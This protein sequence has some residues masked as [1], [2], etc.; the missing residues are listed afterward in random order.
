[1][2][3]AQLIT[4]MEEHSRQALERLREYQEL[5]RD[6]KRTVKAL[7]ALKGEKLTAGAN[8]SK[9]HKTN[10]NQGK[11]GATKQAVLTVLR[12]NPRGLTLADLQQKLK[13]NA[14]LNL[15]G[16]AIYSAMREEAKSVSIP[17][18]VAKLYRL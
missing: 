17:G 16:S 2:T 12:A 7:K 4:E 1:M 18:S 3:R 9:P 11:K 13:E 10:G 8:G 6:Y 15:S 5:E 14:G